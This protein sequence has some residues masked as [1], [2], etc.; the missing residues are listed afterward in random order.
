[1]HPSFIHGIINHGQGG[2]HLTIKGKRFESRQKKETFLNIKD[3]ELYFSE[4]IP[5]I[6]EAYNVKPEVLKKSLSQRGFVTDPMGNFYHPAHW[7]YVGAA[8][9]KKPLTDMAKRWFK[10]PV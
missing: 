5:V 2:I 6:A 1:M 10:K 7:K 4:F 9:P 8:C 3:Y